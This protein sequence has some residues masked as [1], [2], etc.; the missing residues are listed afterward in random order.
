MAYF[1]CYCFI[2][3]IEYCDYFVI[4]SILTSVVPSQVDSQKES[5]LPLVTGHQ[6]TQPRVHLIVQLCMYTNVMY[7]LIAY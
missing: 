2:A 7:S 4:T 1:Y 6:F 3:V 5:W